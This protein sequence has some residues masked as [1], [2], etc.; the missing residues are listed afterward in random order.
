MSDKFSSFVQDLTDHEFGIYVGYQYESFLPYA[1]EIVLKEVE[2]RKLTEIQLNQFTHAKLD[3]ANGVFYCER[4]GS[5]KFINDIDIEHTNGEYASAEIEITTKRC[6]LCNHNPSKTVE[7][8]IFKRIK[9]Y[10]FDDNK[11]EKTLRTYYWMDDKPHYP[12]DN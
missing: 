9:R 10:F 7:K 2:R 5:N 3:R 1:K 6:R 4:C 11:T 8:N 12:K